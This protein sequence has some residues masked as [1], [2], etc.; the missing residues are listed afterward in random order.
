MSAR[1]SAA[2]RRFAQERAYRHLGRRAGGLGPAPAAGAA[3]V[4]V[5]GASV[6]IFSGRG[7]RSPE[8]LQPT[9]SGVKRS[10]KQWSIRA[11]MVAAATV[12]T[13]AR[14]DPTWQANRISYDPQCVTID[15][16]D[17]VLFSGAF[18]YFRCPKPLWPER[19][20]ALKAA[21]FNAVETYVAWN[22]HEQTPPSS[23]DDYSKCDLTDLHDW[24][25][26]ATDRFG[27]QVILR[28]GPYI[29]A[30]WDGGGYPQWLLNMRPASYTKREWY[31]SGDPTYL[32]WCKHW[33][34]A[35][36]RVAA[37]FQ[38]T[39]RPA[40]TAGVV[41]WQIENEYDYSDQ[42]VAVKRD[43]LL[44]LAHLSRD[45]GID[46][47]LITC[48]T[49]NKAF[50]DDDY[51][52]A[53][54]VQTDNT[55]P[56]FNVGQMTNDTA[57]GKLQP[58]KFRMVTELQGGWFAQ[59]GGK[60]SEEQGYDATH[61]N[62]VTMLAWERGFTVT[63]YYM[64]FG[65][66]NFGD[67]AAQGLTTTYDYDAPV[68]ESG[69][70]TARYQAVKA[71]GQFVADHGP[72]LARSTPAKA[73]VTG[74]DDQAV[75]ATL[76]TSP[77]GGRFLFVRADDQHHDHR[78]TATVRDGDNAVTCTYDLGS[79]GAKVLYLP[80]GKSAEAD[81][82][83]YPKP[84]PPV[85]RPTDLPAPVALTEVK[86]RVDLGPATWQPFDPAKTA[87]QSGVYDRQF[88]F[89]RATVPAAAAGGMPLTLSADL[90]G[91][92]WAA[93]YVGGNRLAPT[94]N[95]QYALGPSTGADRPMTV[96]YE[97]AGRPNFGSELEQPS[98][99][100]NARVTATADAPRPIGGWKMRLLAKGEKAS[101]TN[102]T[103]AWADADVTRDAGPLKPGERAVY[104]AT[105]DL[106][107][108]E[109]AG[110]KG[111]T[112]GSVDDE[113]V[114]YVNGTRVGEGHDW[115]VPQHVEITRALH[116]G[117]NTV[118]V[119]VT[120]KENTGGLCRGASLT[121]VGVPVPLTWEFS[122]ASAGLANHWADPAADDG[123][124]ETVKVGAD[125]PT[126]DAPAADAAAAAALTWFRLS[127]DTP[128]TQP[129]EFVPFRLTLDATGNGFLYL[130]GH[131]L[132][133]Y[134]QVGPQ[135]DFYLPE[136]WL[137]PAGKP[138]VVALELRP[139]AAAATVRSAV[140]QPYQGQCEV[141]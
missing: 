10:L 24:L 38:V 75:H 33:Y 133:R 28:P 18:H 115:S 95:G 26:M 13:V 109:V 97:N 60:L 20:A 52:R 8:E 62:H 81:G 91:K 3:W 116:A 104:Q 99:L 43:Q 123:Q 41:L 45:L 35:V 25:A 90:A 70:T 46:V 57:I 140:V 139:T 103:A 1:W 127:F 9:R 59:V 111:L 23:P 113:G 34:T 89:Y 134:W 132:G 112:L 85:Q 135:H 137:A 141:R 72:E 128:A 48:Q 138:N 11:L 14:G 114:F 71:L 78:G 68:R 77:G 76:R 88:V 80:P 84:Q 56:G 19:F 69:G 22:W 67:W 83:W 21:G 51:L 82:V 98:G 94:A 131:P 58:E 4:Y 16:H 7:Q 54:V 119:V 31:R 74:L 129:N 79:F 29:C 96:L 100:L 17:L 110:G 108:A 66:T 39:H 12:P 86:R 44:A 130:N 93:V 40:G 27:L 105:V 37:P 92:D 121:P 122:Q 120:N 124:W 63:N 126:P 107:P 42:P 55:Y 6:G 50:H 106:T 15:G 101:P 30:E 136:C 61:I 32:A 5:R 65:G 73:D 102:D 36:A 53:N 49:N 2:E 87:A 118:T 64:G 125:A 117:A 47:P